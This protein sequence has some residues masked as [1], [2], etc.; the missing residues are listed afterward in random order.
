MSLTIKVWVFGF[1]VFYLVNVGIV[2]IM[3]RPKDIEE[4][5]N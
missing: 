3:R 5:G 4:W 1:P 2:G